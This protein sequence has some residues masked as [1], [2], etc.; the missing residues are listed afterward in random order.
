LINNISNDPPEADL[1]ETDPAFLMYTSGTT[2][3]PKGVLLTHQ[4]I[5]YTQLGQMMEYGPTRD[6]VCLEC[7]AFFHMP[8]FHVL[9]YL[10]CGTTIVTIRQFS[11]EEVLRLVQEE[12]VTRLFLIVSMIN[13]LL[14]HPKCASYDL[15]SLRIIGY[16]GM[17][18]SAGLLERA[19]RVF[20]CDFFQPYGSTEAGNVSI[21]GFGDHAVGGQPEKIRRLSSAGQRD[22]FTE[23]KILDD[24]DQEVAIGEVGEIVVKSKSV[25]MGYWKRPKD[26][27]TVLK[28]SWFHTGDIGKMDEDG[29][30]Y[31]VDRKTDMIISGG[32]NIYP[33]EIEE[34]IC[35]HPAVQMVAVI[36]VP[37]DKWGE[38]VKAVIQLKEGAT[39]SEAEIISF[40]KERLAGYK[41]PKTVDFVES[42]PLN[43]AGKILKRAIK[44]KYWA[45]QARRIS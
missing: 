9:G 30:L 33:K 35:S 7:G 1:E 2:G 19:M 14:D 32:E 45:G 28:N 24:K 17:P 26:T 27:E 15:R 44:E 20:R 16:G 3:Y 8:I 34:V 21:L 39:L 41:K 10:M 29:Y 6:E 38:S 13:F 36:G 43:N 22:L 31:L 11:A 4:N 23:V 42:L 12:K 40:C 5:L 18:I 25:T 37:D